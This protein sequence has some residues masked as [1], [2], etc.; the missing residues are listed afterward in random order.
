MEGVISRKTFKR[1]G[2]RYRTTIFSLFVSIVM[3]VS[4]SAFGK[5]LV[6]MGEENY[7][8]GEYDV[9]Y[10]SG[11]LEDIEKEEPVIEKLKQ[12]QGVKESS[13]TLSAGLFW[14]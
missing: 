12:V 5:Y 4:A 14:Y 3:F 9:Y 7:K 13:T 2:K 11:S 10:R 6:L 8:L 1:S